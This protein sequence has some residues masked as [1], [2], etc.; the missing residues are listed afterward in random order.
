M[1]LF[2]CNCRIATLLKTNNK[3][4]K[5]IIFKFAYIIGGIKKYLYI[6]DLIK[7]LKITI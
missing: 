5:K 1:E 6:F 4:N 3:K 7:F 2:V